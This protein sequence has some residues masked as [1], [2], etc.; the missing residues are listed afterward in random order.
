M[1][2]GF[3]IVERLDASGRA[4]GRDPV[5]AVPMPEFLQALIWP[6]NIGRAP[7]RIIR[8][9]VEYS[10][11]DTLPDE[12]FYWSITGTN[13]VIRNTDEVIVWLIPGAVHQ[14]DKKSRDDI[15]FNRTSLW[16]YG[17]LSY[18]GLLGE[19]WN[20]GFSVKWDRYSG[21][22]VQAGPQAYNYN[23]KAE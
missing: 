4:G 14:L 12:P 20:L 8:L 5:I 3:K 7:L 19:V 16:V 1:F 17:F 18:L 23:R 15:D 10:I 6:I 9:C 11:V 22:L 2:S 13:I 21:G